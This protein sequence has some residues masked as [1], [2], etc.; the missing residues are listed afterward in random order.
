MKTGA[1]GT[2][3]TYMDGFNYL[4]PNIACNEHE[5]WSWSLILRSGIYGFVPR[6]A[7][8]GNPPVLP[9]PLPPIYDPTRPNPNSESYRVCHG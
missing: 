3:V 2:N 8:D 7:L 6:R 5:Q 9:Q 1:T 4:D